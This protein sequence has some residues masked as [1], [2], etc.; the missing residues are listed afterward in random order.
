VVQGGLEGSQTAQE[1]YQHL[2]GM[3]SIVSVPTTE[4]HG[5]F[6]AVDHRH[7]RRVVGKSGAPGLYDP[8]RTLPTQG[9]L[10]FFDSPAHLQGP[11]LH[12][13]RRGSPPKPPRL[14]W[15]DCA[16]GCSATAPRVSSSRL[17][18][19]SFNQED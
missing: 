5:S 18:E 6:S 8:S 13:V 10:W 1:K 12:R 9:I 16:G 19:L 4:L 11:K 15:G 14:H 2:Q 3:G 7:N 17:Q